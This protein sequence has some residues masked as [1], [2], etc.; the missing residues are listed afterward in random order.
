MINAKSK[1]TRTERE[2]IEKAGIPFAVAIIVINTNAKIKDNIIMCKDREPQIRGIDYI[3]RRDDIGTIYID[4]KFR[5]KKYEFQTITQEGGLDYLIFEI[6]KSN[7]MISWGIDK[8]LWTDY[9]ID[10]CN[11]ECYYVIKAKELK[12]YLEDRYYLYPLAFNNADGSQSI[13]VSTKELFD[14]GLIQTWGRFEEIEKLGNY[15]EKGYDKDYN[16]C[17]NR[18]INNNKKVI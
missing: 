7:G 6:K 8:S 16:E 14:N 12:A 3:V 11:K 5:L 4:T 13:K 18:Y 9:I 15:Y 1:L 2:N 17:I 10:I